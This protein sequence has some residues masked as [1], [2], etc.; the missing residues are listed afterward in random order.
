[1]GEGRARAK[2]PYQVIME[3]IPVPL[4][5][6]HRTMKYRQQRQPESDLRNGEFLLATLTE[7]LAYTCMSRVS[8]N[9]NDTI[10]L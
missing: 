4:R 2:D 1:M 3:H 8:K 6:S 7:N 5:S 9:E 10:L